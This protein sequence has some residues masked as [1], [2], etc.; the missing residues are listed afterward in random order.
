VVHLLAGRANPSCVISGIHHKV[1]IGDAIGGQM[2]QWDRRLGIATCES[3]APAD[4]IS[5]LMEI[6]PP[7]TSRC[8]ELPIVEMPAGCIPTFSRLPSRVIDSPI[9][10]WIARLHAQQGRKDDGINT[11]PDFVLQPARLFYTSLLSASDPS[12]RRD[13]L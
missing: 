5:A 3:Y 10:V 9:A 2:D 13:F 4:G 6:F 11:T 8:E 12:R 7:A 1:D